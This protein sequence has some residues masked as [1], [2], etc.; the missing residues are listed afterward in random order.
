MGAQLGDDKGLFEELELYH[1]GEPQT[2]HC[3]RRIDTRN[4]Q[5]F[6]DHKSRLLVHPEERSN[7]RY[8]IAPMLISSGCLVLDPDKLLFTATFTAVRLALIQST[9]MRM[10][11]W[12]VYTLR[13][14]I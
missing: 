9:A 14:R 10:I 12:T 13:C 5:H 8:F 2:R 3:R 7:E 4:G 11:I 1:G 6:P